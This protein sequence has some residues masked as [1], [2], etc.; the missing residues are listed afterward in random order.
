MLV[1][2]IFLSLLFL[3]PIIGLYS[4]LSVAGTVPVFLLSCLFYVRKFLEFRIRDNKLEIIFTLWVIASSLWSISFVS[5]FSS[6]M[7]FTAEVFLGFFAL[8]NIGKINIDES[9]IEKI[10][11]ISLLVSIIVFSIETI[12]SGKVS[13]LFRELLQK[14]ESHIFFLHYLDRGLALLTLLSWVVISIFL[15]NENRIASL[16]VYCGLIIVLSYSDNLAALVAHIIAGFVFVVTRFTILKNP[17]ILCFLFLICNILMIIFAFKVDALKI[18]QENYILPL[19]AKHRLFIWNFVA[20]NSEKQPILGIG[21]NGSRQ[22]SVE[23]DQMIKLFG[24]T[25]SP[26]PLHPHNN[27]MQ[28]YFELGVIGLSLYLALACNYILFIGK[29]YRTTNIISQDLICSLYSCFSVYW[30]MAMISYSLWQSWWVFS[31][32]WISSL[33]SMLIIPKIH[34]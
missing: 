16:L 6:A 33:L 27:V 28:V 29:Y 25:L 18:A 23:E 12:T 9:K 30:I 15:K 13:L 10:L 11:I 31:I 21:F 4:G 2:K 19:S 32:F 7:K 5:I 24:Q 3:I 17:K 8:Q 26:L 20:E 22:F 34:S 14:K 1:E